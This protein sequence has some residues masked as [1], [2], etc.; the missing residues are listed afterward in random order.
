MMI[1]YFRII[2]YIYTDFV[3]QYDAR[4]KFLNL[5]THMCVIF[6]FYMYGDLRSKKHYI[7]IYH[8]LI[9]VF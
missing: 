8:V 9:F 2:F 3:C 1:R 7:Y 6:T 5:R 4:K